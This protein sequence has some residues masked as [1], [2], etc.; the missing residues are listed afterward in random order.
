MNEIIAT[1]SYDQVK[2]KKMKTRFV[3]ELLFSL[4][5]AAV[6]LVFGNKSMMMLGLIL[7]F[8]VTPARYT[9]WRLSISTELK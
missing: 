9:R 5:F 6:F 7:A 3:F 2:A 8:G 1:N 4:A